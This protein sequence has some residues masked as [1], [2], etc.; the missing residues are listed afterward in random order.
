MT[1]LE[2]KV[3][4]IIAKE[5]KLKQVPAIDTP[6][7]SFEADSLDRAE[8]IFSIEDEFGITLDIPDK[9]TAVEIFNTV[10]SVANYVKQKVDKK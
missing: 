6:L 8:I 2:Q 1:D 10:Q 9:Q 5:L 3:A 7:S 4:E